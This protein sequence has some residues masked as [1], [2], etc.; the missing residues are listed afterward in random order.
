MSNHI[1]VGGSAFVSLES[2][3]LKVKVKMHHML[4]INTNFSY[5]VRYHMHNKPTKGDQNV[6]KLTVISEYKHLSGFPL[7]YFTVPDWKAHY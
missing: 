1:H 4:K 7:H 6:L 3:K 5:F 2:D